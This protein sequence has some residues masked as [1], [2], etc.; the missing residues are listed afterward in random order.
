MYEIRSVTVRDG[1]LQRCLNRTDKTAEVVARRINSVMCLVAA[2]ARYHN[3]CYSKF[4]ANEPFSRKRGRPQDD[5]ID[6][7]F[8][9]VC[10]FV[11]NSD[12]CQFTLP[13]LMQKMEE[14][15]SE[16]ASITIKMLQ[17]KLIEEYGDGVVVATMRK[18][19]TVAYFRGSALKL[20]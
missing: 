15:M 13:E 19:P 1:I 20:V 16:G 17:N 3:A 2:E 11:D 8:R 6:S 9:N 10:E 14:H 7:A 18:R 12:E 5:E 4:L